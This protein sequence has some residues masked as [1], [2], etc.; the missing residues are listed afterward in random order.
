M[1]VWTQSCVLFWAAS[2]WASCVP[3]SKNSQ[4]IKDQCFLLCSSCQSQ[5]FP[6]AHL[7]HQWGAAPQ[8]QPAAALAALM[9]ELG[10]CFHGSVCSTTYTQS[11]AGLDTRGYAQRFTDTHPCSH[12]WWYL[13]CS[14]AA[15]VLT[16]PCK[17]RPNPFHFH[18]CVCTLP[19][20]DLLMTT[21]VFCLF[22]NNWTLYADTKII[23]ELC[24]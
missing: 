11:F 20:P 8:K 21:V 12:Q 10:D 7:S 13:C 2:S 15:A 17:A 1:R 24:V 6:M 18:T 4:I 22:Q 9:A 16:L 5:K 3:F 19:Q 23:S 14:Q